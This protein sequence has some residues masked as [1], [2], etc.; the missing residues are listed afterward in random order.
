MMFGNVSFISGLLGLI[1]IQMTLSGFFFW[2][3][4]HLHSII[5]DETSTF[6]AY[7]YYIV[8]IITAPTVGILISTFMARHVFVSNFKRGSLIYTLI[9]T[10]LGNGSAILTC[11][12]SDSIDLIFFFW[13]TLFFYS[14]VFANIVSIMM[15]AIP[16]DLNP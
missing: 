16:F 6:T 10:I 13:L 9:F 15:F 11:F 1:L 7:A 5:S 14:S 3:P 2:L 4:F 8:S 12:T